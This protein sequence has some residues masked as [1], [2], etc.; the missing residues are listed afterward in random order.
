MFSVRLVDFDARRRSRVKS[1]QAKVRIPGINHYISPPPA[2]LQ[3]VFKQAGRDK[4]PIPAGRETQGL[5]AILR[6]K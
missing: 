3:A 6:I 2:A 4:G 5:R 1:F